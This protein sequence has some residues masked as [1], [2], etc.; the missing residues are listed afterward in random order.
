M[1]RHIIPNHSDGNEREKSIG[2]PQENMTEWS[3]VRIETKHF[4]ATETRPLT[5]EST[6][7]LPFDILPNGKQKNYKKLVIKGY[8]MPFVSKIL[9]VIYK[10]YH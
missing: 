4:K 2:F 10:T 7:S 8:G 3:K 6:T 5:R 1:S 9:L